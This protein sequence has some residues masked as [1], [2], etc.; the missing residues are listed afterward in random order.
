MWMRLLATTRRP[1]SSSILV[2]APVRLRL[3]A[4]GLMIEK[5]RETAIGEF[6]AGVGELRAPLARRSPARKV[7]RAPALARPA[8]P[9]SFSRNPIA[10]HPAADILER[11]EAGV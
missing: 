6:L 11:G 10:L 9:G 7:R 5:V 2:T 1:E 8:F 3:V 4:S